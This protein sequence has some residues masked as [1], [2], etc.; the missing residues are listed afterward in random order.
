MCIYVLKV[1]NAGTE[2]R[3]DFESVCQ[4]D[5]ACDLTS[6]LRAASPQPI[7][8]TLAIVEKLLLRLTIL[9]NASFYL[10][11]VVAEFIPSCT[12]LMMSFN[13]F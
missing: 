6:L 12:V 9:P 8:W 7:M 3:F 1:R 11:C 13:F 2:C 10:L 4:I 5:I